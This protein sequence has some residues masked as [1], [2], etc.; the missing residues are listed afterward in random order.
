M[1]GSPSQE[2]VDWFWKIF[3]KINAAISA[4]GKV[5][6][7]CSSGV[8]RSVAFAEFVADFWVQHGVVVLP[9]GRDERHLTIS[10]PNTWQWGW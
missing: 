10:D 6:I 9:H 5:A 4:H 8:H 7:V 2:Q 3:N 1:I